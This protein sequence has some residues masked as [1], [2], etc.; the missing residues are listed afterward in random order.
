MGNPEKTK[1]GIPIIK[2]WFATAALLLIT[3]QSVS[4]ASKSAGDLQQKLDASLEQLHK[5]GSVLQILWARNPNKWRKDGYAFLED[6]HHAFKE[7][8][9]L[10]KV[11]LAPPRAQP[12]PELQAAIEKIRTQRPGNLVAHKADVCERYGE[13]S[14]NYVAEFQSVFG[15]FCKKPLCLSH[16]MGDFKKRSGWSDNNMTPPDQE[17]FPDALYLQWVASRSERMVITKD[18]IGLKDACEKT[19]SDPD[20]PSNVAFD[21]DFGHS[22]K[23]SKLGHF[24]RIPYVVETRNIC[25]TRQDNSGMT[26]NT[27]ESLLRWRHLTAEEILSHF[28][29]RRRLTA[30]EILILS[31]RSRRPRSTSAEVV[32][33]R[34]LKEITDLQ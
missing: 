16:Q 33:G 24:T 22:G 28:G 4:G 7:E 18:F 32:L 14:T 3:I 10:L 1:G 31:R 27:K 9:R 6:V 17:A 25:A 11:K 15:D 34:L 19:P 23:T 20:F 2:K 12:S 8:I 30:E 29:E 13:C 21:P 5:L 26:Q